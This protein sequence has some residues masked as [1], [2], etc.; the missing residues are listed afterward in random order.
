MEETTTPPGRRCPTC[1][2]TMP[3]DAR[4]CGACGMDTAP[5]TALDT[6][7]NTMTDV[8]MTAAPAEQPA[9]PTT[10]VAASASDAAQSGEGRLCL[11]CGARS[12]LEAT[13]C[14]ACGAVFPTPEGDAALEHA[15]Q[16]RI[17]AMESELKQ[18]R[19]GWWPFRAR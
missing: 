19:A 9:E 5:D 10:T 18:P 15:A 11:W 1:G 2:A 16:A 4:F 17:R 14:A 13:S 12:P 7:P 3:A 6:A 8:A